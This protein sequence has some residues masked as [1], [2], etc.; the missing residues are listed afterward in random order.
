[1]KNFLRKQN[2]AFTLIETLVAISIFSLSTLGLLVILSKGISDTNYTKKKIIAGYL[3]QEG[4]E[5]IRNMRDT[6]VLYDPVDSQTG[7]TAFNTKLTSASCQAS[8]GCYFDA[9][10]LFSITPPMPMSK[11]TLTACG[12]SCSSLKFDIT[13]GKYGYTSGEDSGFIRKIKVTP[14]GSPVNEIKIS[15][16]VYW[17]QG[18]GSYN[19]VF[20]ENLFNWIE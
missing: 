15:S 11:V 8:N 1:M 5:Y 7:W 19:T 3:A 4:I 12:A 20:Q 9:D 13:T 10:N 14:V 16:T 2:K 18:S 17:A 6:F